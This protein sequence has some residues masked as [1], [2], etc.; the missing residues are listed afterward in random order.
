[1]NGFLVDTNVI[2][3]I[4]RA[5]P[6]ANVATWSQGIAKE[7]LF[8]S[9]ISLGELRKGLTIMAAGA[10]RGQLEKSIEQQIPF[11]FAGRILPLTQLIAERWGVLEGQRQLLGRPLQVP[12]WQIAATA[13][14]HE[15]V[16]VT[17]NEKDF[18]HLGVAVFNPWTAP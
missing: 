4:L 12:D 18:E 13:L 8:L 15:L 7:D 16:V 2:S 5:A 3:E 1:M 6:D 14:V 17:R 9:V 11:W 10:R